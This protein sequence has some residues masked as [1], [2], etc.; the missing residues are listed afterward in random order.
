VSEQRG[1]AT[2]LPLDRQG[3][4]PGRNL[5]AGGHHHI[6]LAFVGRGSHR[7]RQLQ[8]P[9]GLARQRADHHDQVVPLGARPEAAAGNLANPAHVR[10]RGPSELLDQKHRAREC[11]GTAPAAQSGRGIVRPVTV[12]IDGSS[13][14]LE[15]MAAVAAG[16][17]RVAVAPAALAAVK[18]ARALVDRLAEAPQPTY[19]INT[20]F[21]KLAEVPV[22]HADLRQ[23]Q[24]NLVLSHSAGVGA[25]LSPPETRALMLLRANVLAKG[26]SGIRTETLELLVG[27]LN[28]DVLPVV[29]ERG[30]VGA[31][32]DLAPLAHL[33]LTLIGEGEAFHRG[34]RLPSRQALAN[35]GLSPR[36]LEAK[37]GLALVNGTQA[38]CA[39]GG[40]ALLKAER[41]AALADLCGATAVE[42][43]LGSQK[44]FEAHLHA[45]R[46]HPGQIAVAANLAALLSGSPLNESHRDCGKVQDAYS[47][48]CMPQVHGAAR[49]ALAFAR[50]VLEVELNAATDNP[51]VFADREE[52]VSGGNFHGQPVSQALDFAAIALAQLGAIS[53]RRTEQLVN[54]TLSGLPPFLAPKSGLNSGF[55]IA[56][57]TAAALVAE[58][59]ILCHPACV[60]SIPTSA[61]REDHVSMGMTA[62][63][64]A[65]QVVDLIQTVL[66]IELL[67]ACQAVDLRAP[68][69]P[70][71]P[72]ARVHRLVRS[73]V[74][75]M[76]EDR[77][78][79]RDIAAVRELMDGDRL[80]EAS[81]DLS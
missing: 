17:A 40:L 74:P 20:G 71:E 50:S 38:M 34:E 12:A 46:P 65:R 64:K 5:L 6:L 10:N 4:Q 70:A 11:S 16:G 78:L 31:S 66:A 72:I 8:Q 60:D 7:L 28:S 76:W 27:M 45:I 21:G 44:P 37:E 26:Y 63:L 43:M 56:Q 68:V 49:D 79:H 59:R 13:L 54:P 9:V 14:G 41:L 53:E 36:V 48:R 29:P 24:R 32:G 22:A 19:G 80:L 81:R 62:A 52:V 57:V 33:A 67:V 51:L 18:R 15:Q 3:Q 58:S 1:G 77:E 25:P 61:G 75:P 55:M 30:S 73:R 47:L 2:A 35:A 69:V 39:V 42:G 23:L